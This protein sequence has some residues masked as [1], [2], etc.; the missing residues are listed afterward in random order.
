M[1]FFVTSSVSLTSASLSS[2]AGSTIS[3]IISETEA[4]QAKSGEEG[5]TIKESMIMASMGDPEELM[6]LYH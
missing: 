4:S 1:I 2:Q 5:E 6:L 3:L